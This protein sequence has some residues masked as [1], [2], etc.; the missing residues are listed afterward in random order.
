VPRFASAACLS[1][2][3]VFG[4]GT[5]MGASSTH[6]SEM[7]WSDSPGPVPA[8]PPSLQESGGANHSRW[9]FNNRKALLYALVGNDFGSD[10]E[11]R[12]DELREYKRNQAQFLIQSPK[13]Q[14]E[15]LRPRSGQRFSIH[16]ARRRA[17]CRAPMLPGPQAANFS[18][19]QNRSSPS[20]DQ[21]RP[22][23]CTRRPANQ[24]SAGFERSRRN[25]LRR[26]RPQTLS[27]SL[28]L[29]KFHT[30]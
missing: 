8:A 19:A 10:P 23:L 30:T 4:Q 14:A 6:A 20:H 17:T 2:K 24:Q 28:A 18:I 15:G 5:T 25:R 1:L 3:F 26:C 13:S 29:R 11:S 22:I 9:E 27:R 21:S 7:D 16:R 12:L